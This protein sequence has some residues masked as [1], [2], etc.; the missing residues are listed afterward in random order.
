VG[1]VAPECETSAFGA[2]TFTRLLDLELFAEQMRT[3]KDDNEARTV[4]LIVTIESSVCDPASHD[5]A[6]RLKRRD[7][8]VEIKRFLELGDVATNARLRALALS[9]A[10]Q[11]RQVR[12][13]GE[14]DRKSPSPSEP[15][16]E[17][18]P[19]APRRGDWVSETPAPP[20][21]RLEPE[22]V[23]SGAGRS[24]FS[25]M[26]PLWG[27]SIALSF[28]IAPTWLR[29][30]SDI[31]GLTTRL[32]D[33]LGTADVLLLSTGF[34]LL[35]ASPRSDGFFVGPRVEFGWAGVTAHVSD[36]SLG[37][38]RAASAHND[39]HAIALASF[40]AGTRIALD[41]HFAALFELEAG[42]AVYGLAVL[43]DDRTLGSLR[44]GFGT[45]RAG[46]AFGY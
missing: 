11:I 38:S 16:P 22:I 10:E 8:E 6:I 12:T 30:R 2:N 9:V 43:A 26:T 29:A 24:F 34:A 41:S 1:V 14:F 42:A 44:G 3:A 27:G 35:A 17:P 23:V 20:A 7:G 40:V 33:E 18:R 31:A 5:V 28:P 25:P 32:G 21:R 13:S 15:P 39:S 36:P 37:T 46:L 45:V 4:E 19:V